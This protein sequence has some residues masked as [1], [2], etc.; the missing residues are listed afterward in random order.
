M[1]RPED[2]AIDMGTPP[3]HRAASWA[4]DRL[5]LADVVGSLH[6]IWRRLRL[7]NYRPGF[8]AYHKVRIGEEA[9]D[10]LMKQAARL[11]AMEFDDVPRRPWLHPDWVGEDERVIGRFFTLLVVSSP[12]VF[13]PWAGTK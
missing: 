8:G 13:R 9:A 12:V 2:V 5:D 3:G 7:G 10:V 4:Y 11:G 1:I 6:R